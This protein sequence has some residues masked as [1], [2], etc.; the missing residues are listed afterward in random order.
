MEKSNFDID[1]LSR[2]VIDDIKLTVTDHQFELMQHLP[3]NVY[4]DREKI[5]S[6][7]NNLITNAVKYSPRK[8]RITLNCE[9]INDRV[10]I[11][12]KDEGYGISKADQVKIFE[13]YYRVKN[14]QAL[15]VSGF[16]IGLYLSAEIV[17]RHGG[18]IWVESE[19]GTGSTFYFSLP[20]GLKK[21]G[22]NSNDGRNGLASI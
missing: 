6:V 9:A 18:N 4:A 8:S 17:E 15:M 22:I 20:L 3:V 16:G 14:G 5:A 11:S 21:E 1:K 19:L 7:L 2:D 12:I 10:L 13:R